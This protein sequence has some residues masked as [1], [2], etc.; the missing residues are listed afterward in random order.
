M[1]GALRDDLTTLAGHEVKELIH[2]EGG[3]EG[4]HTT[5]RDADGLP[6]DGTAEGSILARMGGHDA[7]QAVEADRVGAVQQLWG[8]FSPIEGACP[9]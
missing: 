9:C 2:Q 5:R 4:S 1:R 8:V 6:A 7:G 3:R